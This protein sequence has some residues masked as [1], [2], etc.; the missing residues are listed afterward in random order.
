MAKRLTCVLFAV[1]LALAAAPASAT[2]IQRMQI[3]EIESSVVPDVGS[4]Q[5]VSGYIRVEI[6]V[7]PLGGSNT[8][9]D[10]IGLGAN[11]SG[12]TSISLD[13]EV[14][15]PGLGVLNP[16]GE[17][18]IPTLFIE[19]DDGSLTQF[20]ITNVLG[21]VVFGV[22][23]LSIDRVETSFTIDSL[24]PEGLLDVNIVAEVPEPSLLGLAGGLL[25]FA[26]VRLVR[27]DLVRRDL[28]R[29]EVRR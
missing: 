1:L 11:T 9:F 24:G 19:V 5:S 29:R 6:G 8:T 13:P 20:A 15:N 7:L 25:A 26:S 16:A 22:G 18:L 28:V 10:L 27:R 2:I 23:G 14:A 17:F 21:N 4:T 12:G 3:I